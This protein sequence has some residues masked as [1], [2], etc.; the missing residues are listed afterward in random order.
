[1]AG[2]EARR[3]LAAII[4]HTD[5]AIFSKDP[6][7]TITSWNKGAERLYRYSASEAIGMSVGELVPADRHGEEEQIL[8]RLI[9]GGWVEQSETVRVRKDGSRVEVSLT[10][11]R[12]ATPAARSSQR[13]RSRGI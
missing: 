12:F 4:E 3:L 11:S 6:D 9:T 2:E 10:V 5:D 13:Q 7:G 8:E 1:M